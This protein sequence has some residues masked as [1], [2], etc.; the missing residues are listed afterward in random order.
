MS[1]IKLIKEMLNDASH[2]IIVNIY[3]PLIL[4]TLNNITD[5]IHIRNLILKH[6][7]LIKFHDKF[8]RTN[9]T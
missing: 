2:L 1:F 8:D 3:I 6:L 9:M 4:I 5:I 7:L